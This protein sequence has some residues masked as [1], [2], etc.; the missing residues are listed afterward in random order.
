MTRAYAT[1][2]IRVQGDLIYLISQNVLKSYNNGTHYYVALFDALGQPLVG[3]TIQFVF[4]NETLTYIEN[5]KKA[6]VEA[7]VDVY[8][9]GHHAYD[10]YHPFKK[11][12]KKETTI[13]DK[14]RKWLK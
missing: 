5:L 10:L 11:K 1:N 13:F 14:I 3:K 9:K 12:T 6:G 8:E 7:K 4:E 2:Y